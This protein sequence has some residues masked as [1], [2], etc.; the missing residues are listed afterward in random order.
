MSSAPVFKAIETGVRESGEFPV[1]A[2]EEPNAWFAGTGG[3]LVTAVWVGKSDNTTLGY[4]EYGGKAALPIW[5]DYMKTALKDVPIAPNDP[6]EGM[7]KVA[8][9][10]SGLL[11]PTEGSGGII[12]YVKVE[13]LERMETYVDYGASDEAVPSEDSFNIF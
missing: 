9:T 4:R 1:R 12:E 13:D 6:P 8:V 10:A 7:V 5:I 11:L 2:I 3:N